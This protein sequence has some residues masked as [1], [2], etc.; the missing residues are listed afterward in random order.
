MREIAV[1]I[2]RFGACTSAPVQTDPRCGIGAGSHAS[3]DAAGDNVAD[4]EPDLG[5]NVVERFGGEGRRT[6]TFSLRIKSP[7]LYH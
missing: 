6:R 4:I 7:M 1:A 2:V 5:I 3:H